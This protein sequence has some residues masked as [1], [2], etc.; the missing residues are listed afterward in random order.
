MF[1]EM[2]DHLRGI[3]VADHIRQRLLKNAEESR[4][5]IRLQGQF[6][7]FGENVAFDSGARLEFIRLPLQRCRQP[8]VIQNTGP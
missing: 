4:V 3:G 2:N 5:D 6:A 1:L 8:Q 7:Y